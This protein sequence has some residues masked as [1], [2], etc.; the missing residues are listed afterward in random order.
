MECERL[1]NRKADKHTENKPDGQRRRDCESSLSVLKIL[2]GKYALF[3]WFDE[4]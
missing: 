1:T 2:S 4:H 3:G